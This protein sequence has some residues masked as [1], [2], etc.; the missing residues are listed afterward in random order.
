MQ[1]VKC[2]KV[3]PNR[4][5]NTSSMKWDETKIVPEDILNHW[6]EQGLH[7]NSVG[8]LWVTFIGNPKEYT[9]PLFFKVE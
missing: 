5:K 4:L 1:L 9:F 2:T 8:C 6:R 3:I 7:P